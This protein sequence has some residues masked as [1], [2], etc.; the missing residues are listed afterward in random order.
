[1][2]E[3]NNTVETRQNDT[4]N[5]SADDFKKATSQVL[6]RIRTQSMLLGA[7]AISSVILQKIEVWQKKPGKRTL[8]DYKRLIKDI[9]AYCSI[10]VSKKVNL[11]GTTSEREE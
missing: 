8:N 9:N 5:M 11:D 2:D 1:M 4:S 6:E 3:N 7:Q 10:G